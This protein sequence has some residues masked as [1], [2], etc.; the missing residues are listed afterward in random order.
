MGDNYCLLS[1][2]IT[3]INATLVL[4]DQDDNWGLSWKLE[5]MHVDG[6][7]N[8]SIKVSPPLRGGGGGHESFEGGQGGGGSCKFDPP[9]GQQICLCVAR[10]Y[11]LCRDL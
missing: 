2:S 8:C 1:V 6:R 7:E 4:C 10:C 9:G 3:L 5:A 11:I